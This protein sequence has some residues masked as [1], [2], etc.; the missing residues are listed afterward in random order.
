MPRARP[1][2][3]P[4]SHPPAGP[5]EVLPSRDPHGREQHGVRAGQ[6]ETRRQLFR[7]G[8]ELE[9]CRWVDAVGDDAIRV[10]LDPGQVSPF[11]EA[12]A[13]Y[14]NGDD[15]WVRPAQQVPGL[16]FL[17]ER[18]VER[19]NPAEIVD[20]G[21]DARPSSVRDLPEGRGQWQVEVKAES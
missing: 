5:P 19:V 2:R 6:A 14:E 11:V 1:T 18:A 4:R 16:T 12:L 21:D 13:G 15:F 7:N 8:A 9:Q 20:P 10:D 17:H 3:A